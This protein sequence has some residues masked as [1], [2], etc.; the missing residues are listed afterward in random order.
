MTICASID[1]SLTART[2]SAR[3]FEVLTP[4]A[5]HERP[6]LISLLIGRLSPTRRA[7]CKPRQSSNS[8]RFPRSGAGCAVSWP[9]CGGCVSR[10]G[11][12]DIP[13]YLR[14]DIG[15]SHRRAAPAGQCAPPKGATRTGASEDRGVPDGR[16]PV[17]FAFP[18]PVLLRLSA[19]GQVREAGV[20]RSDWPS[21]VARH[22]R[23]SVRRIVRP[24]P[25]GPRACQ[26]GGAQTARP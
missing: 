21:G 5:A 17:F 6:F 8:A 11:Q 4:E 15:L 25:C 24:A 12:V 20:H 2:R 7:T 1:F 18:S 10:R 3:R 22:D 9:Q 19:R 26:P 14:E 16:A 23:G 13:D